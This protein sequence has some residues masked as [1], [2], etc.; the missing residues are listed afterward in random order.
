MKKKKS[1]TI[2]SN[3]NNKWEIKYGVIIHDELREKGLLL[4]MCH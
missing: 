3:F 1:N 2:D 4:R